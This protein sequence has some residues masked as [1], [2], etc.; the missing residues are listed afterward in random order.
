MR[1]SILKYRNAERDS[2]VFLK[3]YPAYNYFEED[4]DFNAQKKSEEKITDSLFD[5]NSNSKNKPIKV[6]DF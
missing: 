1:L 6:M 2:E 3:Y 4:L 5:G